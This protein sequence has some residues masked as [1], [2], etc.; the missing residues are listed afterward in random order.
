MFLLVLR[1][2]LLGSIP[3]AQIAARLC[4]GIDLRTKGSGNV[5]ATSVLQQAGP[6][7]GVFAALADVAKG[8]LAALLGRVSAESGEFVGVI[9]A[10][11]G[12]NW[13]VWLKFHG[14]GGL[15]TF[16]GGMLV[17]ADWRGVAVVL[18]LWGAAY[19]L[20]RE[21]NRSAILAC[22]MAPPVL[23]LLYSSWTHF[24]FGLGAGFVVGFK[25]FLC[26]RPRGRFTGR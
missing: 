12:H 14:G 7:P 13:P 21:H 19:L 1:S 20:V 18:V 15:A 22:S 10:M 25:R 2:Y 16:I 4:R 6:G 24:L 3:F 8:V 26:L 11:I 17:I 5:G 23:G 9:W